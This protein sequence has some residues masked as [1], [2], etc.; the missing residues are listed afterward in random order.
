MM[1]NEITGADTVGHLVDRFRSR[2]PPAPLSS[3]VDHPQSQSVQSPH[4][5][6]AFVLFVLNP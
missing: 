2:G 1:P 3:I 6:V 4:N 5:F